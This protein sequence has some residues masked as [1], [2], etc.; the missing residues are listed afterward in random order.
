[1]AETAFIF[2]PRE[3]VNDESATVVSWLVGDG[4]QVERGQRVVQIETSK[5]V[6]ELEAPAA[7]ILRQTAA[8]G[9]DVPIGAPIGRVEGG[10]WR[11]EGKDPPPST[12]HPPPELP[13]S[14]RGLV[15]EQS[16]DLSGVRGTGRGGRITKADV[17]GHM[18]NHTGAV[19]PG[20]NPP[21]SPT[22]LSARAK[23]LARQLGLDEESF[24]GRGLVRCRD[25]QPPKPDSAP[26]PR[27]AGDSIQPVAAAGVPTRT[28]PLSRAK[29]TE[30]NYLRSGLDATLPSVVTIPCPTRG[31]RAAAK[32]NATAVILFEAARLLRKYPEFNA[33]HADGSGHY[34]QECNIGFA[35]DPGR[36]LRVPVVKNAD[37]KGLAAI[38]DE[39]RDLAVACLDKTLRVESLAGGTFTLTDLS[40]EGVTVFHPLINRGQS[41]ILGVCAEVFSPGSAW[42]S[43]NLVLAFDH[44]LGEGR[45]AASFLNELRERIGHHESSLIRGKETAPVEEPRCSRCLRSHS[46]LAALS[47]LLLQAVKGD[48]AV[49]LVCSLCVNGWN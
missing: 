12:L 49:R 11:V 17:L 27:N 14:V 18:D 33:F 31:F 2:I 43:F 32:G 35:V 8:A 30:A 44:Q 23:E 29:R 3:N 34:Y 13:P 21:G 20:A 46:E 15:A 22:R 25:I 39:M 42:G 45:T 47:S 26:G 16:L 6:M 4:T 40:G 1:M 41:A 36:S 5:A 10:G 19:P 28:E 7:G 37:R 38:A 24:A 9:Q 48:G